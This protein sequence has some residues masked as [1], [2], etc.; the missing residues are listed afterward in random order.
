[1]VDTAHQACLVSYGKETNVS[2]RHIDVP[3]Q[4]AQMDGWVR[5]APGFENENICA[6][7]MIYIEKLQITVQRIGYNRNRGKTALSVTTFNR[8]NVED[9]TNSD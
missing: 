7:V 3:A 1:M 6:L 5:H 2:G 8:Y 9:E 4:M